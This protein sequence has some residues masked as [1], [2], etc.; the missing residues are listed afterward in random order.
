M[1][2]TTLDYGALRASRRRMA[3][4][5]RGA[6]LVEPES[7][8]IREDM[9][10]FSIRAPAWRLPVLRKTLESGGSRFGNY[11]TI[12]DGR[13]ATFARAVNAQN[14]LNFLIPPGPQEVVVSKSASVGRSAGTITQLGYLK[15]SLTHG[16]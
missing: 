3:A 13:V 5:D 14:S 15:R 6:A 8:V 11:I 12:G 2:R 4:V 16:S 10:R 1:L 7:Q 9:G